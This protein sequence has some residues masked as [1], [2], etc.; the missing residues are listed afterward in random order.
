MTLT[1]VA[2]ALIELALPAP[3]QVAV[4]AEH[5]NLVAS[6]YIADAPPSPAFPIHA[7]R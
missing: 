7:R 3:L 6:A 1:E 2:C 4:L 5:E